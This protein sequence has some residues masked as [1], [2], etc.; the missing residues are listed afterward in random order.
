MLEAEDVEFRPAEIQQ[1]YMQRLAADRDPSKKIKLKECSDVVKCYQKRVMLK[2]M[3]KA[4]AYLDL[5]TGAFTS[6]APQGDQLKII[7]DNYKRAFEGMKVI[8]AT[9]VI[10]PRLF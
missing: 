3:K 6:T 4:D 1:F 2:S 9:R 5:S 10:R 8:G 7:I